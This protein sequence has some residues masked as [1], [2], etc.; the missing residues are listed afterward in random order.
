VKLNR[1]PH[2]TEACVFLD[3][4]G[5][6][7]RI[8]R[9]ALERG[10]DVHDIKPMICLMFP[11]LFEHGELRPAIEFEDHDIVCEGPGES[12]Y[13][14]S[15]HELLYYFGPELVAELDRLA[16]LHADG[17][18]SHTHPARIPLSLSA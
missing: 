18:K 16:P 9:F 4:V 5:R 10:I 15:R 3:P 1:S 7:C 11:V 17:P 6:G 14:S 8:H 2:N 13:E 12:L